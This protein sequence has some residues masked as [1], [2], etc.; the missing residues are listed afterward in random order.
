MVNAYFLDSSALVKR[1]VPET[2]TVW[3]SAI[4]DPQVG[5]L[6]FAV[7]I[8]WVEVLSALARR[9]RE[10]SLSA[11][12][13]AQ[14]IQTFR[15]DLNTQYQVTA[16]DPAL[17]ET[18]GQL[19]MQY[20]LRAYDAVQLASALQVQSGFAQTPD[21]QLVF[22]SADIRLLNIAQTEGLLTEN[23]NNYP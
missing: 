12:E 17:L 8:T 16:V 2:G 5:N 22:V 15:D 11:N 20:P 1:Y 3:I 9:Q 7:R 14:A 13:V 18:A 19:V 23:P 10:G 21:I 6:L 4:A